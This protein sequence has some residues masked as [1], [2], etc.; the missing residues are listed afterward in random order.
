MSEL[1]MY[2]EC[3]NDGLIQSK[4]LSERIVNIPSSVPFNS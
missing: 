3:Q 1:E 2:K 4:L